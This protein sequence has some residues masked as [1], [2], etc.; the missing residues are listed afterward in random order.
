[1]IARTVSHHTTRANHT[2]DP[3][4]AAEQAI[5]R[6]PAGIPA[7]PFPELLTEQHA[8]WRRCSYSAT[9]TKAAV[10]TF[11]ATVARLEREGAGR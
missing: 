3:V 9:R 6:H 2:S 10:E 7:L 5:E 4:T 1:M 8:A 11:A